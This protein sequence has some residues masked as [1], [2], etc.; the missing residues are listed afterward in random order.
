MNFL[1][2]GGTGFVGKKLVERL[3]LLHHNSYILTR[4]PEEFTNTEHTTYITFEDAKKLPPIYGV[5][6]LAGESLFGYWTK[7]KKKKIKSSRIEITQK[8][9]HLMKN[10]D[11]KPEVFISGSAVGYY[12]VSNEIMFTEETEKPGED[13]L[14]DVVVAWENTA[15]QAEDMA[16]RTVFARFGV[17]LGRDGGALPL[18]SLPTKLFVGGKIGKGEQWTSWIHIDDVVDMLIFTIENEH[19][20]AALNVTAPTPSR[21]KE[22]NQILAKSLRRPY[23]FPTPGLLVHTVT[24]EMSQLVLKGQYVLPNKAIENGFQFTYPTLELALNQL[25]ADV[26]KN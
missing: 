2:T 5:I 25:F 12:G 1:I 9:I 15:K 18:M 4:T 14:A 17:I 6:N 16:I 20:S 26:K 23:W 24:G 10:M 3:T 21:N 22:F 19:I 7:K 11:V 8:I 13:F